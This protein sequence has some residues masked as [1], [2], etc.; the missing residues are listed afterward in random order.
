MG[1]RALRVVRNEQGKRDFPC[2]APALQV[3]VP[4]FLLIS[5][6]AASGAKL[7]RLGVCVCCGGSTPH[8]GACSGL[9][10][11]LGFYLELGLEPE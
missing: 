11:E 8:P 6:G 1:H 4:Q 5:T 3:N 9:R 10:S 2:N 7:S